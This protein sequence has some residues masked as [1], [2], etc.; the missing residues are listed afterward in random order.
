VLLA[1]TILNFL[2]SLTLI[3]LVHFNELV[4]KELLEV[5]ERMTSF[6]EEED[7]EK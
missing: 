4:R 7:D 5:M 3:Y 6:L 2:I 1:L